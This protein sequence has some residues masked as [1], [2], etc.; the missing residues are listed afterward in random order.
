MAE[1][2]VGTAILVSDDVCDLSNDAAATELMK[3]AAIALSAAKKVGTGTHRLYDEDLDHRRQHR[4]ML[5]HSMPEAIGKD[6][7]EL[8]YQP[9]VDLRS[10]RIVSAEALVRWQHPELGLLGPDLFI[11][12]AEESGWIGLLG[13]WIMRKA[14]LDVMTWEL[15]GLAP[16]PIA[17]NI[18][19][20]QLKMPDFIET[21]R[22]A[23]AETGANARKFDLELTEG[24]LLELSPQTLA[25][26]A[27]LKLLGFKLVIDDFGAGHSSFQYLRNFPIDKLKIDQVFVRQLVSGS[28]DALIIR[29]ITSLAQSLNIGLIAEGIETVEQRDFLRDQGCP[30][31]QGH[32]FSMPLAAEDFAWM[33]K[34]KVTLPSF[35][36]KTKRNS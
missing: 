13:E 4:M 34:Q 25:V 22:Q 17:L 35:R 23:L 28:S 19:S 9:L 31:G 24:I 20:V 11:A 18:S 36:Q 27:E 16:P 12:L 14:M 15:E 5:R 3:R 32:F 26:L 29:A 30:T 8:H 10:G 7:F 6:Q 21:I 1:P 2:C 33:I